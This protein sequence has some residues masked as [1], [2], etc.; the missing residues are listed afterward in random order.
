MKR[1]EH[2]APTWENQLW[3]ARK[4]LAEK[5]RS[6]VYNPHGM[7]GKQCKCRSCFCCAAWHVTLE[8]DLQQA[9]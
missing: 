6:A 5:G 8:H 2:S 1:D 3:H 4:L 7:I 9:A